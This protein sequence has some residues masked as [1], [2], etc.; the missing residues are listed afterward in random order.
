ME[1]NAVPGLTNRKAARW[2][3]KA[4]INFEETAQFFPRGR[5]DLTGVPVREEFFRID[6]AP[7]PDP[8][9]PFTVL[10]TGGSQGS[11][12]LNTASRESWPLFA[13]SGLKVHIL[14]QAGRNNAGPMQTSALPFVEIVEFVQDMPA[15]FAQA[16]LIVAR[17][18][19]STV[20]ELAAAG[21]PAIL[22]PFPFAADDHQRRNA[23]AMQ[24]AGAALVVADKDMNGQRLFEEVASLIRNPAALASMSTA[25]RKA[26]KPGAAVLAAGVLESLARN[27]R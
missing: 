25:A 10:I 5:A 15:A 24:R 11:R 16:D 26:G 13:S 17:S 20:S 8:V 3:S 14:H 22:V 12:T 23:E 27:R 21:K 1:P 18:G 2:T 9:R 7:V 6:A 4:L 19:A